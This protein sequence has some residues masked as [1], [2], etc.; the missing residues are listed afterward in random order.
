MVWSYWNWVFCNVFISVGILLITLIVLILLLLCLDKLFFSVF[1][2]LFNIE[3]C[4]IDVH[5]T[6]IRK[7]SAVLPTIAGSRKI[8]GIASNLC[9]LYATCTGESSSMSH[10][11]STGADEVVSY[12]SNMAEDDT[13]R[14]YSPDGTNANAQSEEPLSATLSQTAKTAEEV[15]RS[16]PSHPEYEREILN[17]YGKFLA[18][19]RMRTR[20]LIIIITTLIIS[21]VCIV[22]FNTCILATILVYPGGPCPSSGEMECFHGSNHTYFECQP[23]D[24]VNF[25]LGVIAGTCFRWIA[26]DLTIIGYYDTIGVSAG[27]LTAFWFNCWKSPTSVSLC[28]SNAA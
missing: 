8:D 25:S 20:I 11:I 15:T 3:R 17:M 2:Q 27:L 4:I 1:A 13:K 19:N 23:G 24:T 14:C 10:D 26:R 9:N 28:P 22:A 6:I 18:L 7:N 21:A 16:H 12:N 5:H